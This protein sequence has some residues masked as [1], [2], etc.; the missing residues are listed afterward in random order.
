M[1]ARLNPEPRA[2]CP[3]IRYL[4]H[5]WRSKARAARRAY[6]RWYAYNYSWRSWLPAKWRR[7]IQCETGSD[8]RWNSGTY[9][10]AFGLWYGTWDTY[11]PA[12][13]PS[14]AY[15]ATPRDQYSAALNIYRHFGYGAWGCG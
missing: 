7:I 8:F 12:G 14:S 3:R 11:K 9:E 1:A 13:S 15:L 4:A 6:E 10:G 2:T 5:V